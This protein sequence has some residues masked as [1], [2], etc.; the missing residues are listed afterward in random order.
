MTDFADSR[1]FY[2]TPRGRETQDL[3]RAQLGRLCPCF[4]GGRVLPLGCADLLLGSINAV[5]G[6]MT[7]ATGET[8][9]CLVDSKNKPLPDAD[10]DCVV[11]LHSAKEI[12]DMDFL[13]REI[14]RVLK[15]EGRLLLIVPRRRSAWA[16]NPDTPFGNEQA[17]SVPQIK[18]IL[19][20]QGFSVMRVRS[21]LYAPP[22]NTDGSFPFA[23]GIEK[24]GPL[25]PFCHGGVLVISAR[26]RVY[27]LSGEKKRKSRECADPL[28]PLPLPI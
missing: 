15:G 8:F 19:K 1:N 5:S 12:S 4:F 21:A 10:I 24:I 7:A 6:R 2:Q 13:L 18:K 22:G 3:L 28:L 11:A 16:D 9:S 23:Y 27:G 14:W 25:V 17:Y 26:K 20:A